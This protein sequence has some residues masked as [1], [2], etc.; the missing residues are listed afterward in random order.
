MQMQLSR[1]ENSL[2]IINDYVTK[3]NECKIIIDAN[4]MANIDSI[5]RRW[6]LLV[7][8]LAK[9]TDTLQV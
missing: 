3:L 4:N 1:H 2:N 9:W 8:Q 5:R 7:N 6:Q